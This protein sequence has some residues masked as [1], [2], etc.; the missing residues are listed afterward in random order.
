MAVE[1]EDSGEGLILGGGGDIL[2]DGEVGDEGLDFGGAHVFGVVF[3]VEEDVAFDP[4]FVGL[5]GAVGVVFETDG[6]GDLVEE[7]AGRLWL[8]V[9]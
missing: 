7:F 4:V 1:E 6:V 2:F 5:F 9:D 3:V 8:H